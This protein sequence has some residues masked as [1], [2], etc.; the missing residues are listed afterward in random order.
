VDKITIIKN[1]G[2]SVEENTEL[3]TDGY[4]LMYVDDAKMKM[5]GNL[6]LKMFAPLIPMMMKAIS[7]KMKSQ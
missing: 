1:A 4:I 5:L 2:T 6:N 3:E 7:E